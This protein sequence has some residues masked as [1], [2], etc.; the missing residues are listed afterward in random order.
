M[1]YCTK[2]GT[3]NPDDAANCSKC[4]APLNASQPQE[5]W[6]YRRSY[7][8][9]RRGSIWGI[10]IGLFILLMGVSSLMGINFWDWIWPAFLILIGLAIIAGTVSRGRW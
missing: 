10:G 6:A 9:H 2:C 1:V 8:Y 4:G 5:P 7:R 3:Q